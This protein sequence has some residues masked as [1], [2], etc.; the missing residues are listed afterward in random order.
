VVRRWINTGTMRP[1]GY[2]CRNRVI[3]DHASDIRCRRFAAHAVLVVRWQ[4]YP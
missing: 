3:G 1:L 2:R 4:F